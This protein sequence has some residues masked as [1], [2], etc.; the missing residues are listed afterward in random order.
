MTI[1]V[2]VKYNLPIHHIFAQSFEGYFALFSHLSLNKF[3]LKKKE[4][5]FDPFS[6]VSITIERIVCVDAFLAPIQA[7]TKLQNVVKGVFVTP[8]LKQGTTSVDLQLPREDG[9]GRF[10]SSC[11]HNGE[12]PRFK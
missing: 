5:V 12:A 8:I 7:I 4:I 6:L 2:I 1:R 11:V 10:V 3:N 9:R